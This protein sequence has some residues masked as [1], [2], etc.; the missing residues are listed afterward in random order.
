M[1]YNGRVH[2]ECVNAANPYHECGVA[3]L[4]QIAQGQGRKEKKKSDKRYVTKDGTKSMDGGR[5]TDKSCPKASN[6]FH[7]CNKYCDYKNA[8]ADRQGIGKKSGFLKLDSFGRKQKRS[9]SQPKSAEV[10]NNIQSPYPNGTPSPRS[11]YSLE[12]KVGSENSQ[13]F[14]S[15][16]H[17]SEESHSRNHSLDQGQVQSSEMMPVSGHITPDGPKTPAKISLSCFA[18]GPPIEQEGDHMSPKEPSSPVAQN[19]E[20]VTTGSIIKSMDFSFSGI[21]RASEDSDGDEIRSVISDSCVSVGKYHVRANVAS[22]MGLIFEKYGDI[23]ANCRLESTSLRAYYLECLCSVVQEL[24]STPF[25]QLTKSKIKEMLAVLKDVESAGI[26]VSWL[27][28]ILNQLTVAM[29]LKNQHQTTEASRI[30]CIQ[31]MESTKRELE[32]MTKDLEEKEK[33]VA[34][35]KTRIAQATA[36]LNE[37]ELESSQLSEALLSINSKVEKIQFKPLGDDVL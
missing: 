11:P 17:P 29:E 37:L 36:R 27:R 26:D 30:N 1:A 24:Q 20:E 15:S 18:I 32:S 31:A 13:S 25:K 16:R 9:E 4:E 22:I 14:S 19:V 7:E 3:C 35:T 2:P 34:D 23:A 5:R 28:D 21:S 8:E 10:A 33:A 6:P 12:K